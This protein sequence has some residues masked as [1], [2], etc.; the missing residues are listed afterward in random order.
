MMHHLL[1]SLCFI[2]VSHT[3]TFAQFSR[4]DETGIP[5]LDELFASHYEYIEQQPQEKIFVHLDKPFYSSDEMVWFRAYVL[6]GQNHEPTPWSSILYIDVIAENREVIAT[7]KVKIERGAAFGEIELSKDIPTGT[8]LLRAYTSWMRNFDEQLFFRQTI[9]IY[10]V[11]NE[12]NWRIQN[13]VIPREN[14]ALVR[15]RMQLS[16]I[17]DIQLS[18]AEVNSKTLVGTG[19][20]INKNVILDGKGIGELELFFPKTDKNE[21]WTEVDLT[22]KR[23]DKTFK[24]KIALDL[25]PKTTVQFMPE[26]GNLVNGLRSLVA[27]KAVTKN[28]RS[29]PISGKII[30]QNGAQVTT[31]E[32]QHLGMGSFYLTP[33]KDYTYTAVLDKFNQKVSLP[34]AQEKGTVMRIES[35]SEKLVRFNLKTSDNAPKS[36]KYIIAQNKGQI[37]LANR[38]PA[39]ESEI[40][41]KIPRKDL[42]SGVIQFTLFDQQKRPLAERIIFNQNPREN[43]QLTVDA[44]ATSYQPR[45]KITLDIKTLNAADIGCLSDLSVAV[46]DAEQVNTDG[47]HQADIGRYVLLESEVKGYIENPDFYFAENDSKRRYALDLLLLTQ[48]WRRY[49]LTKTVSETILPTPYSIERGLHVSGKL[50]GA[51]KEIQNYFLS[52]FTP[53]KLQFMEFVQ[54]DS[55]GAFYFPF[56]EHSDTVDLVL[57]T[58]NIKGKKRQLAIEI[59]QTNHPDNSH[60][61]NRQAH[62]EKTPLAYIEA[63]RERVLMDSLF[64]G[65][66]VDLDEVVITSRRRNEYDHNYN[67]N[68]LDNRN[69]YNSVFEFLRTK[70]GG[71]TRTY[72]G[73][74]VL[75]LD[76]KINGRSERYPPVYLI[77]GK[78]FWNAEYETLQLNY[79]INNIPLED[80]L[81]I[82]V[83]EPSPASEEY[84][85]P[86]STGRFEPRQLNQEAQQ[87]YTARTGGFV[88]EDSDILRRRGVRAPSLRRQRN[89][90]ESKARLELTVVN[91]STK[92]KRYTN[93]YNRGIS[94]HKVYGYATPKEF[95]QPQYDVKQVVQSQPDTRPTLYWNPQVVTDANG[96]AQVS[97][98]NSDNNPPMEVII[99]G[100]DRLGQFKT[101]RVLINQLHSK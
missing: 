41:I 29:V 33:Q 26:G 32:S 20:I 61:Q 101:K 83:N 54:P 44:N 90:L 6:D 22:A 18:N 4:F 58:T 97:F 17:N 59:E 52:A 38:V 92:S 98:F 77:D 82:Q 70:H 75:F 80:I 65:L 50:R 21:E 62:L 37:I 25:R 89:R 49:D 68:D 13:A 74:Q 71:F 95:F 39:N 96:N 43:L 14:G 7:K 8:Y 56:P 27:F 72:G 53:R 57:Q 11:K 40:S 19:A 94:V 48:G 3:V 5:I 42:P 69:H 30:D 51:K 86:W 63:S 47:H 87:I 100:T 64:N 85:S 24:R 9:P 10:N 73:Q 34:K 60:W 88:N 91:I 12:I 93:S 15:L 23:G 76:A 36:D 81:S 35:I 84:V 67:P 1:F 46:R 28:G 16:D 99:Q 66:S 55:S 45:E 2:L 79:D 31:F 78:L